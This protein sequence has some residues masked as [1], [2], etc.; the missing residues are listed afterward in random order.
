[1]ILLWNFSMHILNSFHEIQGPEFSRISGLIGDEHF[2]PLCSL[3]ASLKRC[4]G[5]WRLEEV[6]NFIWWN[7]ILS[8]DKSMQFYKLNWGLLRWFNTVCWNLGI[9]T[10]KRLLVVLKLL[11]ITQDIFLSPF[12]NKFSKSQFQRPLRCLLHLNFV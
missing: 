10:L 5:L 1:M 9:L 6:C 7:Y 11:N 12:V 8:F 3:I 4:V 2:P